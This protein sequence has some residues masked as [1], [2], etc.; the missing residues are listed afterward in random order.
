MENND[1]KRHV[2]VA[3]SGMAPA[4]LTEAVWALSKRNKII[5]DEIVVFTTSE[6]RDAI[7]EE[8]L[9]SGVWNR[10]RKELCSRKPQDSK[11]LSLDVSK[12]IFIFGVNF[13]ISTFAL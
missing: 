13:S 7:K 5:V 4:V 12:S 10:L 11:S 1:K 9:D 2:L 6:G 3:V 8:L